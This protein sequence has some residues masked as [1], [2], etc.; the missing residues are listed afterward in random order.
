MSEMGAS[1][2]WRQTTGN[3]EEYGDWFEKCVKLEQRIAALETENQRLRKA[4]QAVVDKL[5]VAP[6]RSAY[7][8]EQAILSLA[9]L[10]E[11]GGDE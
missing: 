6:I 3:P 4:A 5:E 2:S 11:G 10:L 8:V 7:S 9:A 1:R